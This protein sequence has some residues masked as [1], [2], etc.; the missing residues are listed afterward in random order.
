MHLL[1]ELLIRFVKIQEGRRH[2]WNVQISTLYIIIHY[3][4]NINVCRKFHDNPSNCGAG[5]LKIKN[6]NLM[7]NIQGSPK[8]VGFILSASW[9]YKN[10]MAICSIVSKI[11]SVW[12][13]QLTILAKDQFNTSRAITVTSLLKRNLNWIDYWILMIAECI[14]KKSIHLLCVQFVSTITEYSQEKIFHYFMVVLSVTVW[15]ET[16]SKHYD[17]IHSVA[18]VALIKT[19]KNKS[20]KSTWPCSIVG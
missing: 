14:L 13:D 12:S 3:E 9:M 18:I 19:H 10:L 11:F 5:S 6:V 16:G 2:M 7:R 8:L 20:N 15:Q 4:G 17:G 1:S